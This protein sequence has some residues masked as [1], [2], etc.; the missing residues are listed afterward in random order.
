M[1][2]HVATCVHEGITQII[3]GD[4]AYEDIA[5]VTRLD[6]LAFGS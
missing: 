5:E 6:P 1:H 2:I 4:R 3:T